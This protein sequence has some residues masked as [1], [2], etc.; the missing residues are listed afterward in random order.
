MHSEWEFF[1]RAKHYLRQDQYYFIFQKNIRAGRT[2][3]NE[4]L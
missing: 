4:G 1:L 3:L 2:G